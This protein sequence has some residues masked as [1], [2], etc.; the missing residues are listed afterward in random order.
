MHDISE[1]EYRKK[2]SIL[3]G[4]LE[5]L[6]AFVKKEPLSSAYEWWKA[7]DEAGKKSE[8]SLRAW[9]TMNIKCWIIFSST[10]H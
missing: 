5:K 2:S 7:K 4:A 8:S 1:L 10:N 6:P 9:S 3:G